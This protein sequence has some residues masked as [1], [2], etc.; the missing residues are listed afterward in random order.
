MALPQSVGEFLDGKRFA[1]AGVSRDPRQAANAIYRKLLA[2]GYE[3][4]PVNPRATEVEGAKCYPD[5]GAVPGV[6][7][8]LIVA[9]PPAAS[10]ALVRQ[11][12]DR[13]VSRIWFHRSLGE[14]SVSSDAVRECQARSLSCIIGGCPLMY[15]EPVDPFHRC[16]RWVLRWSGHVP[17]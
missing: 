11:C 2:S 5:L 6:V 15:C 1:V 3:V 4:L 8:G 16:L 17:R 14:G 7:D 9:S 12:A 10:L 13:G